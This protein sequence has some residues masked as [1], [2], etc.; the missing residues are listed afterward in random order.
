MRLRDVKCKAIHCLT[1]GTYEHQ[2][3]AD[4]DVKNLFA[5]GQISEE[6]VIALITQT[7]DDQYQCSPHHQDNS[8]D[9]HV[10]KPRRLG[11]RW[12][13][14]FFFLEPDIIFIS[15]HI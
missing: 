13:V 14:K 15:V 7:S 10:L 11:H 8:I 1:E 2:V 6:W 12:Y 3:R 9:V 4:I 5:T